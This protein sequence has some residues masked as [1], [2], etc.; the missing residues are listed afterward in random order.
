[1]SKQQRN[2]GAPPG[3][4][5]GQSPADLA[6]RPLGEVI[7][8]IASEGI[9]P[10][11]GA[12][13]AM[14]LAL[15]AACGG[16][17]VAITLKRRPDDTRLSGAGDRLARIGQQALRGADLDASRFEEFI[18]EPSPEAA[19]RLVNSGEW[20]QRLWRDLER[21]LDEVEARIEPVV[22]GDVKAARALGTAFADIQSENL[23]D[24]R[25]AAARSD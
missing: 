13:G 11:A 4:G 15:A 19:E 18:H 3:A 12:A 22:I 9:S 6:D 7:E 21:V 16:K 14:A 2:G 20:L 25:R 10:G 1:M 17:A 8:S 5:D 23:A 24:N